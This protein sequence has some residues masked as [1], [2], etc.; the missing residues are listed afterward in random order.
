M[1]DS[2]MKRPEFTGVA[3]AP[4]IGQGNSSECSDNTGIVIDIIKE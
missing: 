1:L 3:I 4:G 2:V